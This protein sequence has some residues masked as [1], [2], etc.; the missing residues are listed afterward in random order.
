MVT[1]GGLSRYL[2][3]DVPKKINDVMVVKSIAFHGGLK[4]PID[5]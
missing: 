1:G 4:G 2:V 5:D 3:P